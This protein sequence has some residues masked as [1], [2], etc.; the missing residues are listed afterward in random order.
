[1][2]VFSPSN[3]TLNQARNDR[4]IE[5]QLHSIPTCDENTNEPIKKR[6]SNPLISRSTCFTR[7]PSGR[8]AIAKGERNS[9]KIYNSSRR[10]GIHEHSSRSQSALKFPFNGIISIGGQCPTKGTYTCNKNARQRERDNPAQIRRRGAPA[11]KKKCDW[12]EDDGKKTRTTEV[13]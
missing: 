8:R 13:Q 4:S 2:T 11:K 3:F 9:P 12:R 10:R 6:S 7:A 5:I 1:M